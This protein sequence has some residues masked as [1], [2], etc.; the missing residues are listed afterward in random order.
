MRKLRSGKTRTRSGWHSL[1]TVAAVVQTVV[2]VVVIL[3][4]IVGLRRDADEVRSVVGQAR[5]DIA[6]DLRIGAEWTRSAGREIA[7]DLRIEQPAAR[8]GRGRVVV[9]R[10]N[11][12]RRGAVLDPGSDGVELVDGK[13]A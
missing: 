1:S 3:V 5:S 4:V 2:V 13:I 10:D 8:E 7:R 6:R 9:G 11:T 12:V